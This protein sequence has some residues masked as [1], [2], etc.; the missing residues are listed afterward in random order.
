MSKSVMFKWSET[1]ITEFFGVE[2][3]FHDGGASHSFEVARDGLRLLVTIFG[4]ERAVYVSIF[5]DSLAD[6]IFTVRRE[7]CTHVHITSGTNFRR[8]FEAGTPEH[9]VTDMCIP[10]ILARG[11]RVYVEPHF[12]V[13]LI[14]PR[15]DA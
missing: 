8:C 11:V 1:D 5:R 14:E 10:P 2:A 3:T 6:P 4:F 7:F 13:E 15:F 12:Q 9:E